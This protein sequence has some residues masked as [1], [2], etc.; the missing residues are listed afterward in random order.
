MVRRLAALAVLLLPTGFGCGAP[1]PRLTLTHALYRPA[2]GS[3]APVQPYR[4]FAAGQA[5]WVALQAVVEAPDRP[6]VVTGVRVD[7]PVGPG[8]ARLGEPICYREHWITVRKPSPRSPYPPG[9]WPDALIPT[10]IQPVERQFGATRFVALPTPV[11]EGARAIFYVELKTADNALPGL[12]TGTITVSLRDAEPLR[13][14]FEVRVYP[15]R[16][17]D[18]PTIQTDFG[19]MA[20]ASLYAGIRRYTPA[21]RDVERLCERALMQNR[22]APNRPVDSYCGVTADGTAKADAAVPALREYM[23]LLPGS[24]VQLPIPGPD[25]WGAGKERTIRFVRA[26]MAM[27]QSNGWA[28][29]AYAYP[30]DEPAAKADYDRVRAVS[31][32]LR[33]ADPRVK[34]LL[35]EQPTPERPEWGSLEAHVD[36]WCP[37]WAEWDPA[38]IGEQ[39]A[40]GKRIWSYTALAKGERPTP[41]WLLDHPLLN[42]RVAL[43]QSWAE[44]CTGLLYWCAVEWSHTEDP[45]LNPISYL[46]FNGEGVLLYPGIDAGMRSPVQSLRLKAIRDGTQDYDLLAMADRRLG[47]R[48]ARALC[49]PV[50]RSWFEWNPGPEALQ[51]SREAL[52]QALSGNRGRQ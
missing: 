47:R 50:A 29:Q 40:K 37:L 31:S 20:R 26:Y 16:L 10:V 14:T 46:L 32:I 2:P 18:G 49:A 39:L 4:R 43:W 44:G 7:A 28:D 52:L 13:S 25:P 36:I 34:V 45:W 9:P 5:D 41:F 27:L 48:R 12:Y 23:G 15:V 1:H 3:A 38:P 35:T 21:S 11:R 30:V 8:G 24:A 17:P 6:I 19:S 42:Y 33:R 22:L 51:A